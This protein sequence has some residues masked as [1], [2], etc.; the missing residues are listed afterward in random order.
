[1]DNS[2]YKVIKAV[3]TPRFEVALIE[4]TGGYY[5]VL[6]TKLLPNVADEDQKPDVSETIVDYLTASY[7]FDLRVQDLEGN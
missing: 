7:M 5:R 6:S 1:M 3:Q 4:L 2:E